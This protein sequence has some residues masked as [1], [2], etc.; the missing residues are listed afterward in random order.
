LQEIKRTPN[1]PLGYFQEWLLLGASLLLY[2]VVVAHYIAVASWSW[3]APLV[4]LY[5]WFVADLFL[6][7]THLY[8]DYVTLPKDLALKELLNSHDRSSTAYH[9]QKSQSL[10]HLNLIQRTAFDFKTHHRYPMALGRRPFVL[11]VR[12][13]LLFFVLPL[14]GMTL[15]VLL[16]TPLHHLLL[17]YLLT[18]GMGFFLGQYAHANTHKQRP[19]RLIQLLQKAHLLIDKPTHQK[20]HEAFKESFSILNGWASFIL[21][22]L[23]SWLLKKGIICEESLEV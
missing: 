11:L 1:S 6:G 22:P 5:G 14:L 13:S 12:E 7:L 2:G 4:M 21:N 15:L 19:P 9:Q 3:Y 17:L 18:L 20:H 16:F 8:L 23:A 10:S